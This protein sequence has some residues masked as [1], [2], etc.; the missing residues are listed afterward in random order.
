MEGFDLDP[1]L[2]RAVCDRLGVG[3]PASLADVDR[4]YRAWTGAVPFDPVAKV[5]AIAE[6]RTPPGDDP[7]DLCRRWLATG[8]GATCWGHCTALAGIVGLGGARCTVGLDRMRTEAKVDF[9]SFT[10][11]HD[12]DR[13]L[14]LDPVHPSGSPLLLQDGSR[15][16]H[17]VYRVGIDERDRRLEHWFWHPAVTADRIAYV[18]LSVDL[19]RADVR[20]FCAVSSRFSGVRGG[21]LHVRRCPPGRIVALRVG[22][23]GV[24]RLVDRAADGTT[25]ETATDDVGEAL[26]LA[27][28]HGDAVDL[29]ERSGL[30]RRDGA[31]HLR[32][33]IAPSADPT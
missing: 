14:A 25:A 33:P 8:L 4:L 21:R 22:E 3:V 18:V 7:A 10:V 13:R 29:V 19:D 17:G 31:G 24:A 9:H 28:F 16:D 32:F 30:V 6:G 23:D 27:G 1:G 20:A 11:V 5:A 2:A 15:G 26:A 12:G